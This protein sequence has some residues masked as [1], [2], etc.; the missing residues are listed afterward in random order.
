MLFSHHVPHTLHLPVW[1]CYVG[2]GLHVTNAMFV[3][4]AKKRW[5]HMLLEVHLNGHAL[6]HIDA[7]YKSVAFMDWR[8]EVCRQ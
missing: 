7:I 2:V 3:F 6:P 8:N 1:H 5:S 4:L